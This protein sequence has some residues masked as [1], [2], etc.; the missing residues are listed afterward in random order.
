MSE[1]FAGRVASQAS[2]GDWVRTAGPAARFIFQGGPAARRAAGEAF[3]LSLPE[4]RCRAQS[5]GNRAALW[6]GPDEHLLIDA[7]AG[8]SALAMDLEAAMT[9]VAHSLVDVSERQVAVLFSGPRA[10]EILNGGCPLDLDAA[11]FPPGACARTLLAKAEI[12]LWRRSDLEFHLEVWR[13]FSDYVLAWLRE[14]GRQ[15]S[16]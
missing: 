1:A 9:G 15:E 10:G 5:T 3:G 12:I 13:S 11:A 14:A 6:L 4:E 16:C 7:A 2:S 8:A